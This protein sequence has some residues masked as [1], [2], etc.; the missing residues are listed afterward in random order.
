MK[1]LLRIIQGLILLLR[2]ITEAERRMLRAVKGCVKSCMSG[3]TDI[4]DIDESLFKSYLDTKG[5]PDPDLLI[6]TSGEERLFLISFYGS[7]HIRNFILHGC[8]MA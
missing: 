3:E 2:L 8:F 6:R 1:I 7:L 5:I 4:N